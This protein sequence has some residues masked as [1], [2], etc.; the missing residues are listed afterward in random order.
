MKAIALLALLLLSLV[1]LGCVEQK[2]PPEGAVAGAGSTGLQQDSFEDEP[3][4]FDALG[5]E[6]E[7]AEDLGFDELE[8]A[9]QE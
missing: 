3:G 2:A 4:A 6:L 1:F 8:Q 5:R 7:G 9:L